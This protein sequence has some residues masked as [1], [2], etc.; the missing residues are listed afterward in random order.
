MVSVASVPLTATEESDPL[1]GTLASVQG[2]VPAEVA[3][4]VVALTWLI[5]P[6]KSVSSISRRVSAGAA[7]S[8][9]AVAAKVVP[10][11]GRV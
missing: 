7:L 1:L 4:S 8:V 9:G 3:A 2:V 6:S 11:A 10:V 5:L